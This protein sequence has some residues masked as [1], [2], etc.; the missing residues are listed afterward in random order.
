MTFSQTLTCY[1]A[2]LSIIKTISCTGVLVLQLFCKLA[3]S[4]YITH[5]AHWVS[6]NPGWIGLPEVMKLNIDL[7]HWGHIQC[8]KTDRA[9]LNESNFNYSSGKFKSNT[10]CKM[11]NYP[12]LYLLTHLS[13][14]LLIC[15]FYLL[16]I[17]SLCFVL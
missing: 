7:L 13:P 8:W 12:F 15:S 10:F 9:Y 17:C 6:I 16:I 4:S 14:R 2:L 3:R 11:A 5:I 1:L